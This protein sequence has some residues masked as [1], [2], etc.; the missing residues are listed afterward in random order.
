MRFMS[1]MYVL[2]LL[3]IPSISK[4]YFFG[5]RWE[6]SEYGFRCQHMLIAWNT[7]KNWDGDFTKDTRE[8]KSHTFCNVT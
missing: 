5:M 2:S 3:E 1:Q 4:N 8:I 7:D 6:N